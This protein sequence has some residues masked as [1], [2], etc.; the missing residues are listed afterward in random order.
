VA[1]HPVTWEQI[2][3]AR[4]IVESGFRDTKVAPSQ[5]SHFFHSLSSFQIGYF[6]VN[7]ES[8]DGWIDWTWLEAQPA[9]RESVYVRHLRLAEPLRVLMN[10]RAGEG[11]ILKPLSTVP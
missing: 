3:G 7:P 10:G 6:T 9:E 8:G 11:V 4:A 1:R 5:G 2:S